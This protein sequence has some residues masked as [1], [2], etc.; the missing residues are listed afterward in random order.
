MFY[1]SDYITKSDEKM[2]Q[3][4]SL[5]SKAVASVP[6]ASE[7]RA[8]SQARILLQKCLASLTRKQDIHAQQ[9]VRYLRGYDDGIN[10]HTTV[11]MLSVAIVAYLRRRMNLSQS[12]NNVNGVQENASESTDA[13][14]GDEMEDDI[15]LSMRISTGNDSQL[16]QNSQVDDYLHRDAALSDIS[17]YDFVR[18][19]RKDKRSSKRN[20][21]AAVLTRYKLQE[22]HPQAASH[23]LVLVLHPLIK[24]PSR[25][26]IPVVV[27]TSI[28][29]KERN[30]EVYMLLAHFRP[31]ST[32]N[33]ILCDQTHSIQT[34]FEHTTFT[35][36]SMHVMKNWDAVHECEDERDAERLR[37]KNSKINKLRSGDKNMLADL[38]PAYVAN[39]DDYEVAGCDSRPCV[40]DT[41]VTQAVNILR[42]GN[43]FHSNTPLDAHSIV[44]NQRTCTPLYDADF[45]HWKKQI[46]LQE[47]EIA[48]ARRSQLDPSLQSMAEVGDESDARTTAFDPS[49]VIEKS[50]IPVQPKTEAPSVSTIRPLE[51]YNDALR[52]VEREFSLNR[53]QLI[54]FRICARRFHTVL[55]EE[56]LSRPKSTPLRMLMTGPGGTGKT[57]VVKALQRV[58]SIFGCAHRIRF[59]APTGSA[60]ALIDGQTIHAGLG[61]IVE[62]SRKDKAERVDAGDD[63]TFHISGAR[64]EELR[65]EWKNVDFVMIDECSMLGASLLCKLD[66][67]LRYVRENDDWFGGI[68]IIFS[69]DFYQHLPVGAKPLFTPIPSDKRKVGKQS[70]E[71]LSRMGRMAWKQI[72]IVIELDEQKRMEAD[73]PYAST[74]LRL[75]T[76][77]CI[78]DDVD[79]FNQC[80]IKSSLNPTGVDLA[81]PEHV[82]TTAIVG[83]NDVRH[84][85]N[86]EKARSITL[87]HGRPDLIMCEAR[88]MNGRSE[89]SEQ[90]HNH[91]LYD[92]EAIRSTRWEKICTE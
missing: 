66:A 51:S 18:C 79:I 67:A 58:M 68:N 75:R 53:K 87:A 59:L 35:E 17:F 40:K 38:D 71:A 2:Y 77:T 62:L 92:I 14:S 89:V 72:D 54:A 61:I 81:A 39:P 34:T 86:L 84:A 60:A 55:I 7:K 4:L 27:G 19:L 88:H 24:Q 41:S 90:I 5:F 69:G 47:V 36:R 73:P 13:H 11:P 46:K 91:L 64:R 9:A 15:D 29:R 32:S 20:E 37:K 80:L 83:T 8:T 50:S 22:P 57:H 78:E 42:E 3:V 16:Y 12:L 25:E 48:H 31:F 43:W 70:E 44:D 30:I 45:A 76:R 21:H 6:N 74:V 65:A 23:M 10:S 28:P 33:P 63:Y 49:T 56:S 85:L 26:R 1:I 82:A 52:E